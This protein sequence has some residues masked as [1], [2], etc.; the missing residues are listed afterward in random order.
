VSR[1]AVAVG[2]CGLDYH[3]DN[4][5]RDVQRA[6]FGAH[7]ALAGELR[8]PL[9]VHTREAEEDTVAAI[10]DAE[11]AG[12]GGILH[13]F[14]GS[15]RLAETA[16]RAGWFVSFSGVVTFR[17]WENDDLIRMVPNDRI[18]AETD[19]PYLAPIPHRGRKNEP[20]YIAE[21]LA[22]LASVRG[23]PVAEVDAATSA[24]TRRLFGLPSAVR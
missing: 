14:T 23:M 15:A 11:S 22:A 20:A 1:G 4:S 5:P 21:T 19:S 7:I 6:V 2:E 24:N 18:L 13:C 16:L 3:Y 17:K 12:A 10:R 8:R 9:V